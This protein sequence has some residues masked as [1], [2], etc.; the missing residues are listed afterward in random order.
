MKIFGYTPGEL[1]KAIFG[2]VAP[3]IPLVYAAV[4]V[5]SPGGAGFTTEEI[6]LIAVAA[7]GVG[8]GVFA[9]RN[10]D[11]EPAPVEPVPAEP[12]S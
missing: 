5:D 12:V 9:I 4:Q 6:I 2:F 11:A 1:K 7:F 8:G 3:I 10:K